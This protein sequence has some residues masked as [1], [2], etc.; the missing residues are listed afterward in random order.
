MNSDRK[1]LLCG[2]VDLHV[3]AG[4]SVAARS[5]DAIEMLRLAEDAGYRALVVKDHHFPTMMGTTMINR[6]LLRGK[7][8]I[9]GGLCLNFSVGGWNPP[10]VDAACALGARIIWLPTVSAAQHIEVHKKHFVGTGNLQTAQTPL[11]CLT[12]HGKLR[13]DVRELLLVL[14]RWPQVVMA[15]GHLGAHELDVLIPEAL[16]LG[17]KKILVNHPHFIVNA[18]MAH[19]ARWAGMGAYLEI[20][21]DLFEGISGNPKR[22]NVPLSII[23]DYLNNV[24]ASRLVVDSDCGQKDSVTPDEAMYR[25]LCLLLDRGV[26]RADVDR[27]AKDNPAFLLGL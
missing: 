24:P 14:A 8:Q 11:A 16:A 3:H 5:V 27:M 10:A 21:G 18:T 13:A 4:P 1:D 22:P 20:N 2:V 26:P 25:F 17:V 12:P 7:T 23:D 6:H 15:T 19:A 9:F